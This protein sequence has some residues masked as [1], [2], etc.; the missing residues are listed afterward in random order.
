MSADDAGVP[1]GPRI[2]VNCPFDAEYVPVL[3]AIVFA[4]VSTGFTPWLSTS[5]GMAGTARIERI[6]LEL[7]RA[8]YSIHDLTRYQGEGQDNLARMNM[9]LELG[10]AMARRGS[11]PEDNAH[12]W[13]ALAPPGAIHRKFV[14]DLAGYDPLEHDGTPR[15]ALPAIL[16]WLLALPESAD[17]ELS[18]VRRGYEAFAKR[19]AEL[20]AE[21]HGAPVPWSKVLALAVE[22][23]QNA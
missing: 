2:F 22:V 17:V 4:C 21:W 23:A 19:K 5:S 18:D 3:D 1:A 9:A 10:M 14:S 15:T 6:L 11:R 12:V 8:P 16:S 7:E 13:V 20:V